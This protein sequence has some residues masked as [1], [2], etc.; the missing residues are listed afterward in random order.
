MNVQERLKRAGVTLPESAPTAEFLPVKLVGDLAFVSGHAPFKDGAFRYIGQIGREL[1]LSCGREAA[2]LAVLG[3]LTSLEAH[4]GSLE[5]VQ[6]I[7]KLNGYVNCIPEFHDLPQITDESSRL[8][9]DLFGDS[10]RH[11]RTTV[12]V[13]SLPAGVA[14]EIDLIVRIRQIDGRPGPESITV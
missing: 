14:V 1:D 6:E 12:G 4:L 2:K 11:A 3:C 13:C 9:V 10:G 7:V 8:L 5:R